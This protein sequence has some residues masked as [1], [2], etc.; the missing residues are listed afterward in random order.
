MSQPYFMDEE[1]ETPSKT[2]LKG[3]VSPH[4]VREV[5]PGEVNVHRRY[6]GL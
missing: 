5:S 2:S 1:T 6:E 3:M 4:K